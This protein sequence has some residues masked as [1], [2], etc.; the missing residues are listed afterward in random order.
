VNSEDGRVYRWDFTTNTFS[1]SLTLT[2]GVGEA[3]T[4]TVIGVDGTVYVIANAT[5]FALGR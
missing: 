2:D 4:P 5:L 3:Y 1:E